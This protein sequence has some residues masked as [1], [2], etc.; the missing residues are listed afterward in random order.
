M[1]NERSLV[2]EQDRYDRILELT[3]AKEAVS[4]DI[5]FVFVIKWSPDINYWWPEK[6][7]DTITSTILREG[8]EMM[9]MAAQESRWNSTSQGFNPK[10][11]G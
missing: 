11:P 1:A 10:Q 5:A 9:K 3:P 4:I 7:K 8:R 6:V 2:E